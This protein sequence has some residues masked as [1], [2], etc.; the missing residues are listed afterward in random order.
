M[1]Y[2]WWLH[3]D[4]PYAAHG[5]KGQV[6][7]VV[8]ESDLVVVITANIP[9]EEYAQPQRLIQDHDIPAVVAATL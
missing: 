7:Y 9:D 8:P 5:M 3:E 2:L 6:I 1:G 4:G